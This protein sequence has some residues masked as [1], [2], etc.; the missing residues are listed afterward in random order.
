MRKWFSALAIL[1]GLAFPGPA[2]ADSPAEVYSDFAEDGVLSCGHSR[3]ALN[4]ALNDASL[5]QYGD[6]LTFIQVKL[7][8]RKQL[9]GSCRRRTAAR[10]AGSSGDANSDE[11]SSGSGSASESGNRKQEQRPPTSDQPA[12]Q[13]AERNR[14]ASSDDTEQSGGM[15]LLGVGLLLL[16]LGSGG[17]AARRAFGNRQ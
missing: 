3:S 8:I 10:P 2:L 6:P 4:G 16:T 7:A 5:H 17:W 12:P 14:E 13:A 9:A 15:V 11:S 1:A